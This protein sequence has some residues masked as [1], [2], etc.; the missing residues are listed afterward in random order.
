MKKEWKKP[1][2]IIIDINKGTESSIFDPSAD[3]TG[4]S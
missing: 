1:E 3:A 2:L 4:F